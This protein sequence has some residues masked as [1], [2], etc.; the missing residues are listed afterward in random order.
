[1]KWA[2]LI[3]PFLIVGCARFRTVQTDVSIIDKHGTTS[4][5]IT[6]KATSTTFFDSKSSLASFRASQ[7]DKSQNA[8]VGALTQDAYGTNVSK[9]IE[10]V[11]K[12]I[13]DGAIKAFV[14]VK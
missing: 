2:F 11:S 6:T 14:P 12:G 3:I 13:I 4:R 7:T 5:T 1:M 9:L 10:S 8:S